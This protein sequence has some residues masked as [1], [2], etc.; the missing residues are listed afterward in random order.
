MADNQTL[1][2]ELYKDLDSKFPSGGFS[3]TVDEDDEDD[4]N[5]T[6][7]EKSLD[8]LYQEL[9]TKFPSTKTT[10]VPPPVPSQPFQ[11]ISQTSQT[12]KGE[13][14]FDGVVDPSEFDKSFSLEE[15]EKQTPL[16]IRSYSDLNKYY[17]SISGRRNVD[18]LDPTTEMYEDLRS[19]SIIASPEEREELRRLAQERR[20][21]Y[22][23]HPDTKFNELT[24][25]PSY[26]G[27]VIPPYTQDVTTGS[28]DSG[29]GIL[30]PKKFP[31]SP[32]DAAGQIAA[33]VLTGGT[34][35]DLLTGPFDIGS[36][37]AFALPAQE[38]IRTG[39]KAIAEL[40]AAGVDATVDSVFGVNPNLTEKA[41]SIVELDTGENIIDSIVNEGG[42][43]FLG[44]GGANALVSSIPKAVPALAKLSSRLA[45]NPFG[46]TA[47]AG[48]KSLAAEAGLTAGTKSEADTFLV[49]DKALI[50]ISQGISISPDDPEYEQILKKRTNILMDSLTGAKALELGAKGSWFVAKLIGKTFVEPVKFMA[51]AASVEDKQQDYIIR[52][53]L[54]RLIGKDLGTTPEQYKEAV[55]EIIKLIE[56]GANI[57]VKIPYEAI[58]DINVDVDAMSAIVRALSNSPN[59]DLKAYQML[60]SHASSV[61]K[62]IE[63]TGVKTALTNRAATDAVEKSL[64]QTEELLGLNTLGTLRGRPT[65]EGEDF[66]SIRNIMNSLQ[67]V[68]ENDIA[69]RNELIGKLEQSKRNILTEVE[70]RIATDKSIFGRLQGLSE[71]V[72]LDLTAPSIEAGNTISE[73]L[74]KAHNIMDDT[75]NK[76]FASI[77]GGKV[78][79]DRLVDFMVEIQPSVFDIMKAGGNNVYNLIFKKIEPLL[80]DP[81]SSEL[82]ATVKKDFAEWAN[83]SGLDFNVLYTKIRPS[84]VDL[85]D[86]LEQ[87]TGVERNTARV[88]IKFK[89]YIDED[90]IEYVKNTGD[91][92]IVNAVDT[93]M[94][95]FREKY[96]PVWRGKTPLSQIAKLSRQTKSRG[97]REDEFFIG[98][99]SG[100]SNA[101]TIKNQE[102]GNTLIKLLKSKE[103]GSDASVVTD[104][105]IG[106]IFKDL[107]ED[108]IKAGGVTKLKVSDFRKKLTPYA[109]FIKDKFKSEYAKIEDLFSFL[110]TNEGKADKL[111]E[112]IV[113]AK[114]NLQKAEREILAGAM[115]KFFDGRLNSPVSDAFTVLNRIFNDTANGA[116]IIGELKDVAN[117]DNLI[118][119]GLQSAFLRWVKQN[120]FIQTR[121]AFGA[122]VLRA[123]VESPDMALGFDN[124][125]KVLPRYASLIFDDT[126]EMV[127]ALQRMVEETN[128]VQRVSN[129]KVFPKDSSTAVLLEEQRR[130]NSGITQIFGVLSRWG[131]RLRNVAGNAMT[132]QFNKT[133]YT[134]IQD[135]LLAD[136]EAFIAAAKKVTKDNNV[137]DKKELFRFFVHVGVYRE[138]REG[139]K[140]FNRELDTIGGVDNSTPPANAPEKSIRSAAEQTEEFLRGIVQPIQQFMN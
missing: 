118:D 95:Y 117:D 97:I 58:D 68:A 56:A 110:K 92:D 50:P 20:Q 74:F 1:L 64:S 108:S 135:S 87:G 3:T 54:D 67:A 134:E 140:K 91:K 136:P 102:Y 13:G 76:L 128:V 23:D 83:S 72:G 22:L 69:A 125:L 63:Q 16:S 6:E 29:L 27:K 94:D 109:S 41:Q 129:A 18:L 34:K 36:V 10:S 14:V 71:E 86:D 107:H 137:V 48:G 65:A 115:G 131:A 93:A 15:Q 66:F 70:T 81:T 98:A 85:I 100:I 120:I 130:F 31:S 121:D 53:I 8:T 112:R 127:N 33:N 60:K 114:E 113:E 45:K 138:D 61:R 24:N 101:L 39:Q 26:K 21:A 47:V 12:A 55:E 28:I 7:E 37:G 11:D 2:D 133:R 52:S 57:N 78:D 96:A 35:Q 122:R 9:D 82:N 42:G 99:R 75:K 119:Y 62:T 84:L 73:R 80:A 17:S 5:N 19:K 89:N 77:Q 32:L 104:F 49:G 111:N 123:G 88:L 103:G 116:R 30:I 59:A 25:E 132:E 90:A 124:K 38:S 46:A 106:N 4:K 43:M 79:T 44:L 105:I 139:E 51:S 40:V 126:P